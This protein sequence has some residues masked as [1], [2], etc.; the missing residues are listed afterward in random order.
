MQ[1]IFRLLKEISRNNTYKPSDLD[2]NSIVENNENF[3]KWFGLTLSEKTKTLPIMN[4]L[5]S[6]NAQ[7]SCRLSLHYC[8]ENL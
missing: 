7:K 1:K 3:C 4:V 2:L 6:K 5:D 8:F